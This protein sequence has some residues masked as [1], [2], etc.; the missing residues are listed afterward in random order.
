[1]KRWIMVA[2]A[3]TAL[4]ALNAPAQA[5]DVVWTKIPIQWSDT[6]DSTGNGDWTFL[7][8]EADTT[9]TQV[10]DT[11]NWAWEVLAS[12][13]YV[14]LCFEAL[15][16]DGQSDSINYAIEK[17]GESGIVRVLPPGGTLATAH[18]AGNFARKIGT[19]A[20]HANVVFEGVLVTDPD[21]NASDAAIWLN[22][23]RLHVTGD[24]SGTT[25]ALGRL[26]AFLVAPIRAASR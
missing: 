15:V 19:S 23:F 5:T 17:V 26:K 10:I 21:A 16:S 2:L 3:L 1:M 22:D 9:R 4:A 11:S 24:I 12:G 20:G 6:S 8:T 7:E 13:Q 14:R 18:A 25:P